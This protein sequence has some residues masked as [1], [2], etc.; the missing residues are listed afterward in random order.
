[1]AEPLVAR[2]ALAAESSVAPRGETPGV[3]LRERSGLTLASVSALKGRE[4]EL[5]DTVRARFA[6]ELPS[7]PK[8]VAA[9]DVAFAWAG[10]GR[11]LAIAGR[12]A[13]F[14]T[15]PAAVCDQSDARV[16]IAASGPRVR[17]TLATLIAVDLHPRA[18]APGDVA[19]THAASIAV[20]L[21]QVDDAP[22]FEIAATRS[23][24]AAL[25]RRLVAAALAR[26]VD[27]RPVD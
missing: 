27:A 2:S 3:T 9:G 7:S 5:W 19:L 18:F 20:H 26:D 22:T 14:E 12:E 4:Q 15:L 16:V 24:A 1:M 25:W 6:L 17:E 11:W 8:H 23:Y 13:A 21:W 10:P